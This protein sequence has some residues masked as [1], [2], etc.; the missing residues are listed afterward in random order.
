M[1]D[2][3]LAPEGS[4][5]FRLRCVGCEYRGSAYVGFRG[6]ILTVSPVPEKGDS[7]SAGSRL[8][9][10]VRRHASLVAP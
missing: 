7:D 8:A 10:M 2:C 3:A 9:E 5:G 6:V 4:R 1:A